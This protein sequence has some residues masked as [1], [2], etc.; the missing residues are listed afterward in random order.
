M[1]LF[2]MVI[3]LT[4][5]LFSRE[6]KVGLEV[7]SPLINNSKA[8]Y[9]IDLLR[10]IEKNSDLK[11][12][13]KIMTYGRAKREL[14]NGRVDLIGHT[15]KGYESKEFYEYAEDL[16]WEIP[17]SSDMF[18]IDKKYLNINNLRKSRVGTLLGN[19][20]FL[21]ES[22][23]IP[24]ELFFEVKNITQLVMMLKL[25]RLDA[26]V[27][28]RISVTQIVKEQRIPKVF[29]K[30]IV[31][32]PIG[33][34]VLKSDKNSSLKKKLDSIIRKLNHYEIYNKYISSVSKS[35]EGVIELDK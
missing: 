23:N 9:T 15:P 10:A 1:K 35:K 30:Q 14:K 2:F 4:C 32:I 7:F 16:D 20:D 21:A 24:R 19:A 31:T 12:K 28:E 3:L 26:I 11:F 13:I 22:F 27:F 5:S 8:G 33:F 18:V 6:V 25:K 34:A 17:T 29:Y